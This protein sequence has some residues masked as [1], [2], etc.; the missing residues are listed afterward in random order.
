VKI[1]VAVSNT[2][3]TTATAAASL[4]SG[5]DANGYGGTYYSGATQVGLCSTSSGATAG[6]AVLTITGGTAT[7]IWEVT[8]ANAYSSDSYVFPVAVSYVANTSS[9]IPGLTT[10]ATVAGMFAPNYVLPTGTTMSNSLPVPRFAASPIN[11]TIFKIDPCAT[12]LLFPFVTNKAG[13][14]SGL[15]I[16]NTSLDPFGTSSQAGSCRINYYSNPA[17]SLTYE[18]SSTVVAGDT[19]TMTLS[20]G[21][22]AFN[23]KGNPGFQGYIIAQCK[24]QYA[25]GFAFITD[26]GAQKL[27][28]GYLALVLDAPLSSRGST[29][30]TLNN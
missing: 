5:Y 13:F 23:I 26:L 18:D 29:S 24:F 19:L 3:S 16:S 21:N 1:A 28:E 4:V 17:P 7:A 14:D 20:S 10:G 15:A 25:H 22:P 30:E 6:M 9:N 2:T 12:N 27:A 11:K 8:A